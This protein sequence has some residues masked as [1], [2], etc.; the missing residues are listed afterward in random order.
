VPEKFG[1]NRRSLEVHAVDALRALFKR[2]GT[3]IPPNV[4]SVYEV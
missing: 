1:R 2:E 4:P 3:I